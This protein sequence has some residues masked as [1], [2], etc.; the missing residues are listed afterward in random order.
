MQ[1]NEADCTP[2]LREP[3]SKLVF[4]LTA[5]VSRLAL[6]RD[7]DV[8]KPVRHHGLTLDEADDI[9]S[10]WIPRGPHGG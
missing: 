1:E 4:T 2:R 3:A 8:S 10:T 5:Q 9:L 7:A 6:Y